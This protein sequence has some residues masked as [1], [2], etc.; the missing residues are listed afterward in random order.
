VPGFVLLANDLRAPAYDD[1]IPRPGQAY[2]YAVSAIDAQGIESPLSPVATPT[3]FASTSTA[4]V[5]PS[6]LNARAVPKGLEVSWSHPA[7]PPG[8]GYALYRRT[9]EQPQAQRLATLPATATRYLDATAKPQVLYIYSVAA[10]TPAQ[11]GP[12]TSEISARR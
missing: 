1:E 7:V 10:L 9:R 12:R 2:Q 3:A 8:R 6:Q 4:P 5:P 11:E